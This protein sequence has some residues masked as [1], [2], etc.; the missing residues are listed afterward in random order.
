MKIITRRGFNIKIRGSANKVLKYISPKTVAIQTDNFFMLTP[1]MVVKQGE[2]V[3][4][5]QPIFYSK[6]DPNIKFVTPVSGIVS[7]IIRGD[8]RKIVKVIVKPDNDTKNTIIH[9]IPKLDVLSAKEIKMILSKS[10]CWP[11]I[12]QRPYGII[13]SPDDVPKSIFVS[14][15]SSNS[16]NIDFDFILKKKSKRISIRIKYSLQTYSWE[17]LFR[18]RKFF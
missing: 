13:A 4:A 16:L 14:T 5:G 6:K 11:F 17:G 12:I 7:E 15:Y 8:K 3:K 1:K 2:K 9:T 10:G 18:D